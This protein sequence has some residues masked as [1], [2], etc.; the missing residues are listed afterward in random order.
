MILTATITRWRMH[1]QIHAA[2]MNVKKKSHSIKVAS[3]LQRGVKRSLNSSMN[4]GMGGGKN[5]TQG[6]T[7]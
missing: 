3:I 6:S 1:R 4:K 5:N 2:I 7:D